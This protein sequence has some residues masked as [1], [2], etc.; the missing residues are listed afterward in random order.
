MECLRDECQNELTGRQ[1]TY[2]SDKCR[3]ARKRAQGTHED[4]PG[5]T[6]A[7]KP[8][9]N[10]PPERGHIDAEPGQ[11]ESGQPNADTL[12][13]AMLDSLPPCVVRPTAQ[14][15]DDGRLPK[16]GWKHT[17]TYAQTI[18]NLLTMTVAELTERGQWIP[19]WKHEKEA[20]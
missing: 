16:T 10:C 8:G 15:G 4:G 20:A 6:N 18:Y 2:C 12:T 3:K 5:S 13:Q 19:V 14:P 17:K 7:D 9:H 11:S 1:R